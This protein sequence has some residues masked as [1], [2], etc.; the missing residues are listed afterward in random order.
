MINRPLSP[1]LNQYF[2][3]SSLGLGRDRELLTGC[4]ALPLLAPHYMVFFSG[5]KT[6]VTQKKSAIAGCDGSLWVRG[7]KTELPI[8]TDP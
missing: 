7:Q 1:I 3:G 6:G 4:I 2:E 5:E 8:F